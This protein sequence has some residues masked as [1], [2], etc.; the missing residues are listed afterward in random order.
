MLLGAIFGLIVPVLAYVSRNVQVTFDAEWPRVPFFI[1]EIS[2]WAPLL[3]AI[4]GI[5][6]LLAKERLLKAQAALR[7]NIAM[8]AAVAIIGGLTCVILLIPTIQLM[9]AIPK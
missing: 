5:M 1:I 6:T 7:A 3:V 4:L 8:I 2:P 9:H